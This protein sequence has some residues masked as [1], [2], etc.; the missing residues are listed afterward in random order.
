MLL[1]GE[2]WEDQKIFYLNTRRA[3]G[4]ENLELLYYIITNSR[5]IIK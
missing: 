5:I 3:V 4:M 1:G 2:Y